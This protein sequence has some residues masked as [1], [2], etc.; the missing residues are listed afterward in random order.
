[1]VFLKILMSGMIILQLS[2]AIKSILKSTARVSK[3]VISPS[4]KIIKSGKGLNKA[5]ALLLADDVNSFK[6]TALAEEKSLAGQADDLAAIKK[7][8]GKD[9]ALVGKGAL[10]AEKLERKLRQM[11][12]EKVEEALEELIF[13]NLDRTGSLFENS[14]HELLNEPKFSVVSRYFKDRHD[15][16]LKRRLDL[17][18]LLNEREVQGFCIGRREASRVLGLY[19]DVFAGRALAFLL[20]DLSEYRPVCEFLKQYASQRGIKNIER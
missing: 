18:L 17:F 11:T 5:S 1:M 4:G 19:S 10:D 8:V 13:E 15:F 12:K 3:T 16:T 2:G 9:G 6:N 20:V 7:E 14:V